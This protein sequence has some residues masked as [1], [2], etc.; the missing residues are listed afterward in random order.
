MQQEKTWCFWRYKGLPSHLF[1]FLT[2]DSIKVE[3]KGSEGN[4]LAVKADCQG[5]LSRQVDNGRDTPIRRVLIVVSEPQI[6][7]P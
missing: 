7:Y 4:R 5:R 3:R 6:K 2:K 1:V